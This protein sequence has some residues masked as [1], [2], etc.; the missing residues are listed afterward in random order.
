MS[1]ES[2]TAASELAGKSTEVG[3]DDDD[4]ATLRAWQVKRDFDAWGIENQ[5][6]LELMLEK[7]RERAA[8]G[9]RIGSRYLSELLRFHDI[10][11][12]D[13]TDARLRNDFT[14]LV[15]RW[16]LERDPSLAPYISVRRCRFDDLEESA[17]D[18]N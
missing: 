18:Q 10:A 16:L 13:G 6:V 14:P 2:P 11:G 7:A 15:S 4:S 17:I 12:A 3:V 5:H 9:Q 1:K 8:T